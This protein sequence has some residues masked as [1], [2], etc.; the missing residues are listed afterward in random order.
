MHYLT[1]Q[2]VLWI[3]HE[4]TKQIHHFKYL[5]LEEATNLQYGYVKSENLRAQAGAFLEGFMKLRPFT[6]GNRKTAFVS[7][8]AFLK[9]NGHTIVLDPNDAYDWAMSVANGKKRG[10]DAI[11]EIMGDHTPVPLAPTVRTEVREIIEKYSDA[12]ERL[13]D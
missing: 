8:L 7:A 9:I 10:V 11:C 4:V 5:Q 6:D 2:D 13:S 12:I 3:N 1:V